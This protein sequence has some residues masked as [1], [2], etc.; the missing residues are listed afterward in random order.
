M[1]RAL[2]GL[3]WQSSNLKKHAGK[4]LYLTRAF[5]YL[6]FLA[7]A[8]GYLTLPVAARPPAQAAQSQDPPAVSLSGLSIQANG[9]QVFR[10]ELTVQL[11]CDILGCKELSAT[12]FIVVREDTRDFIRCWND[13]CHAYRYEPRRD[14]DFVHLQ[15]E[16]P[17]LLARMTSRRDLYVEAETI[18]DTVVSGFG[19]CRTISP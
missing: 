3:A 17:N 15:K 2:P 16:Q 1:P 12:G 11:L 9:E 5:Y 7:S 10:C 8:F 6:L 13:I 19:S 14:G 4:N 18:G